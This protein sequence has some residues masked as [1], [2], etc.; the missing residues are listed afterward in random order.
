LHRE[1]DTVHVVEYHTARVVPLR[2]ATAED[3]YK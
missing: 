1:F 3:K 2:T